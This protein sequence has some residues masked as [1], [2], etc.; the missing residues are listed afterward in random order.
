MVAMV[1]NLRFVD[2]KRSFYPYFLLDLMFTVVMVDAD[3]RGLPFADAERPM[4][5]YLAYNLRVESMNGYSGMLSVSIIILF[6][7]AIAIYLCYSL[8]LIYVNTLI[9]TCMCVLLMYKNKKKL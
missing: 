3:V 8:S 7:C 6:L 2:T 4:L 1:R 9:Y 5:H